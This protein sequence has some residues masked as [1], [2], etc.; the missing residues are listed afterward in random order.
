MSTVTCPTTFVAKAAMT[1]A[2]KDDV[3][4]MHAL[5][6]GTPPPSQEV[7]GH[8]LRRSGA[9]HLARIGVP[10]HWIQ[11]AGR[12]GGATVMIYVEEALQE[13]PQD[14]V[15]LRGLR[16]MQSELDLVQKHEGQLEEMGA[17][18]IELQTELAATMIEGAGAV[19]TPRAIEMTM[20]EVVFS[21][22][23]MKKVHRVIGEADRPTY[24]WSTPCGWSWA[25][26]GNVGTLARGQSM[27]KNSTVCK[28]CAAAL[29]VLAEEHPGDWP[30]EFRKA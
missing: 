10:L 12:W 7:S 17:K 22:W 30:D 3:D 18:I 26:A 14:S 15:T 6:C 21:G 5:G 4:L 23:R 25:D 16:A 2:L 11:F 9:K 1:R 29:R 28:F 20:P 24:T 8:S 27:P 19:E 13:A